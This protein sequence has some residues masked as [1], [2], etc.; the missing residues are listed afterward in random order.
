MAVDNFKRPD[1]K[2]PVEMQNTKH[3]SY[4]WNKIRVCGFEDL[5]VQ[6]I[7]QMYG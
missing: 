3:L 5:D 6:M 2:I 7:I 4:L 1:G